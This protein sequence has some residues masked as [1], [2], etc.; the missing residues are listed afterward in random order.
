LAVPAAVADSADSA[1]AAAAPPEPAVPVLAVL[2]PVLLPALLRAPELL[3][4]VVLVQL[5]VVPVRQ[6]APVRRPVVPAV[7]GQLVPAHR[8]ADSVVL[9]LA[10]LVRGPVVPVPHLHSPPSCSAAMARSTT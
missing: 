7:R 9:V 3:A 1:L 4:P 6:A 10:L 2:A 5:P 8:A